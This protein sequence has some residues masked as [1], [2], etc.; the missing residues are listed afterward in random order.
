M[1]KGRFLS[2]SC[3]D[4]YADFA[5]EEA[6]FRGLKRVT[7]RVWRNSLSVI[8][9]RAQLARLETDLAYCGK[10][11]I[12]VVRRF[13]AGGAVYNGP[14][15][16]NWSL[17]IPAWFDNKNG[18]AFERDPRGVFRLASSVVVRALRNCGVESRFDPPN[19]IVNEE[20]KACGM[21]AYVSNSGLLCHGTLL[22][23][24]DLEEV[25]R[26][27]TPVRLIA[28]KKYVR[29]NPAKM[30]NTWVTYETFRREMKAVLEESGGCRFE[31]SQPS[32]EELEV[33]KMLHD[34]KYGR[35]EWN[36]GDPFTEGGKPA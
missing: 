7:A 23:G 15:N 13:T 24:A 29:S 27:T 22:A 1:L 32:S 4:P 34:E 2:A 10:K 26:V 31:A 30:A 14:G 35:A 12:P 9:G 36:L 3:E 6:I 17:F 16:F 33:A 28:E 19:R 21:A 20:G 11:G 18:L 5:L 8:I 25:A